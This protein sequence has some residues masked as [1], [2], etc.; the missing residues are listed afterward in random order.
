M[1]RS[2]ALA[3]P[4]GQRGRNRFRYLRRTVGML[5]ALLTVSALAA[6]P[7]QAVFSGPSPGDESPAAAVEVTMT[8]TGSGTGVSGGLPPIGTPFDISAYPGD[9]PATYEA[10]NPSFAGTILTEDQELNTQEMYCI[11]IRTSTYSGLGYESG[12]W[13]EANV[14]NV[15]YVNRILNN[16]YPAV[17]GQPA[18]PSVNQQ[19]AAVQAAIWFFSDGFV[20]TENDPIRQYAEPIVN[21][22]IAA[23]PL[24]EPPPPAV[25]IDPPVAS[26]PVDGSTGPFTVTTGEG[27]LLTV[28]VTEGFTLYSDPAGTVPLVDPVPSGTQIWVRSN[29]QTTAPAVVTAR[30]VVPV[31]TG[32]VYLY[33]GNNPQVTAAQK[34]ILAV[35]SEV[36]STAQATAE[37]FEVG[38]LVVTKSFAGE[39][40]GSQDASQL[41]VDCGAP[42]VF[43]IEVPAA[44]TADYPTPIDGIPVG[45][46]C[47][48]TEPV[49]GSNFAVTVVSSAPA[50]VVVPAG[51]A[52]VTVTNTVSYNPGSLTVTKVLTGPAAGLQGNI[53]VTVSCE[54]AGIEETFTI[55][56]GSAAGEYGGTITDIP[57]GTAC[58][59]TEPSS[60]GTELVTVVTGLPAVVTIQPGGTSAAVV[61]NDVS[62]TYGTLV[63]TKTITG[64]GAGLQ[65]AVT[66]LVTCG[67]SFAQEIT[68]PA[69]TTAG[70]QV[71]TFDRV[72]AGSSCVVTETVNGENESVTVD[73]VLPGAVTVLG[74]STA[75]ADVTNAYAVL[76]KDKLAKTGVS[77]AGLWAAGISVAAFGSLLLIAGSRRRTQ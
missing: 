30:A 44:Q 48:V 50:T 41:L 55:P 58:A 45:S 16:Y 63:L 37:F 24:T 76:G 18:A 6:L 8:G 38:S 47:T 74:G 46:S 62:Y 35:T 3:Q 34:L 68:I 2:A 70:D 54:A 42:Y 7:A 60:G 33:A 40:A 4:G 9:V 20:L 19:A 32:N 61:S 69:G 26:G 59:V 66:I 5:G 43:T 39:G 65:G 28:D 77:G 14:P 57:A 13:G 56:A 49:T 10:N 75:T 36:S 51:G 29:A 17:P 67:D 64:P 25:S 1:S 71:A 31:Q 22:T 53:T 12:T 15:G 72:P 73:S 21:D 52:A 23:G 11:D 27:E